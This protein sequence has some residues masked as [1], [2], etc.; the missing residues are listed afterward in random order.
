[1]CRTEVKLKGMVF[2]NPLLPAS[3]PIVEGLDNLLSL[4]QLSLGG[5]VTKTISVEGAK[6]KKPCIVARKQMIF[7]TE[8]W[9]E[10]SLAHWLKILPIL[11]EQKTKPLGI[12]VGYTADDFRKIVPALHPYA[13]FFE[14][15]T[16]YNKAELLDVVRGIVSHTDKPVFIKM[17]PQVTAEFEFVETV[18]A[19]GGAGI[20]A[21]NSFG[22]GAVVDLKTRSL[23]I[24]NEFGDSWVSGPAIKPFALR[25]V[26]RIRAQ[27]PEV[28]II[29]CGGVASAE[30][31]L[32]MILAGADLVQMLSG[33]LLYGRKQY[34]KIVE[35]LIPAMNRYG[36]ESIYA[37]RHGGLKLTP[38][39]KGNFPKVDP[40]KC[41]ACGICI[42]S[43]PFEAYGKGPKPILDQSRCIR[44]G[45]CQSLCPVGAIS[46][47]LV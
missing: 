12:S 35:D 25:R 34:E 18:L 19:A 26:A 43:C 33:A 40:E 16:H 39:G 4:N 1:M 5:L 41:T 15:S 45:L 36:I 32:E 46:E 30:D 17:S 3:G 2:D 6:V 44:C 10:Y 29:A 24:G 7:N 11:T 20:V 47:V 14:V 38:S 31:V 22:P 37:L 21:F 28:P 8:L 23:L 13:D 27:F 9:S 42:R